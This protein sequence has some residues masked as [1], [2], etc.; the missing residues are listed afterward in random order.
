MKL[1]AKLQCNVCKGFCIS[2]GQVRCTP[3]QVVP[4]PPGNIGAIMWNWGWW[5]WIPF[6][7]WHSSG[8][9]N[10]AT[11]CITHATCNRLHWV[12]DIEASEAEDVAILRFE[13]LAFDWPSSI[14]LY[15]D[16]PR[17]GLIIFHSFIHSFTMILWPK[18]FKQ[19]YSSRSPR[20]DLSYSIQSIIRWLS[21][22]PLPRRIV[23]NNPTKLRLG[24]HNILILA[25]YPPR[26][27]NISLSRNAL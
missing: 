16:S 25:Y 24:Y 12:F 8:V 13:S 15:D 23:V 3:G 7:G 27:S 26:Y 9:A 4:F 14:C 5:R 2:N 10:T 20:G 21:P 6:F 11:N 17:G 18:I 1:S 22:K 19:Q